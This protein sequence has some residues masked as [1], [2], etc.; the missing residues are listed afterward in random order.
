MAAAPD[1]DGLTAVEEELKDRYGTPP[2]PVRRLF[3]VAAFRHTCRTHGVREVTLQGNSIRFA[4]LP[5]RDS[6]LVRLKRLYPKANYKPVS[7]LVTV[8]RPTEGPAGGRIGAPPLRDVELLEWCAK[9]LES[10][11]IAPAPVG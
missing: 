10:L 8:P 11:V 2:L 1:A 6:Q 4:P 9:L 3:A 7:E 5:L